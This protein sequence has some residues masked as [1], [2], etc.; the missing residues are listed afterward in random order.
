M[1]TTTQNTLFKALYSGKG[2]TTRIGISL[3]SN[4]DGGSV[5]PCIPNIGVWPCEAINNAFSS[6]QICA[7]VNFNQT[8]GFL[9]AP[10]G[11]SIS[12]FVYTAVYNDADCRIPVFPLA[13]LFGK[14][15]LFSE[16]NLVFQRDVKTGVITGTKYTP[17]D[18]GS[19]QKT[20]ALGAFKVDGSCQSVG[21]F[22][23]RGA[24]V[25]V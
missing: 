24:V 25:K 12:E 16:F 8:A 4:P 5:T 17:D 7:P 23:V 21:S 11:G 10:P 2:C 20:N 15:T 3:S 19:C 14:C 1:T 13:N 6:K 22:Y 9:L 18:S